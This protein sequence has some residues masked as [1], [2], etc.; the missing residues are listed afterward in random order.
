MNGGIDNAAVGFAETLAKAHWLVV[1][2]D[3]DDALTEPD[4]TPAVVRPVE[5]SLDALARLGRLPRTVAAVASE[6]SLDSLRAIFTTSRGASIEGDIELYGARETAAKSAESALGLTIDA[7]RSCWLLQR[8]ARWIAGAYP[9]AAVEDRPFGVAMHVADLSPLTAREALGK[10]IGFTE[11][12]PSAAHVH[13]RKSTVMV[14]MLPPGQDS[15]IEALRQRSNAT[16]LYIGNDADA[17]AALDPADVGCT[18]GGSL[19]PGAVRMRTP[20]EV[21]AFVGELARKRV[22]HVGPAIDVNGD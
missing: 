2:C 10:L 15:L 9:G 7:R 18:V 5:A 17:H 1:L 21:T 22:A 6:R 4:S 16:I 11:T 20:H 14:S 3:L 12:L 8:A 13:R 19:V